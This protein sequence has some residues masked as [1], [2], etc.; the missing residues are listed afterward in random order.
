MSGS[1]TLTTVMSSS[2]MKIATET[3]IRVHHLRSTQPPLGSRS[4]VPARCRQRWSYAPQHYMTAAPPPDR[5]RRALQV[6]LQE[7]H[8]SAHSRAAGSGR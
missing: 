8:E 6:P 3:A 5:R 7:R 1:A 2:S 4:L